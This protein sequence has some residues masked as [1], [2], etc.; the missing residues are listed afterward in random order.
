MMNSDDL[1]L[2]LSFISC[3][4]TLFFLYRAVTF[5]LLFLGIEVSAHFGYSIY[6]LYGLVYRSENG[7]I[8]AWWFNLILFLWIQ[9]LVNLI[10]LL[11]FFFKKNKDVEV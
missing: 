6:F 2:L 9:T 8:F 11:V 5:K 4:L 1:I 7:A 10:R 3:W